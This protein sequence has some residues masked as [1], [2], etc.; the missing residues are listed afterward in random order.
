VQKGILQRVSRTF[1]VLGKEKN[2][3]PEIS[4]KIKSIYKKTKKEFPYLAVCIWN[5][6]WLNE[7][8]IHQP[9]RFYILLEVEKD[10][11]ESVFY[12][13]REKD[14]AVFLEPKKDVF[15]KYLPENKEAI[16]VKSLVSE[17]PVISAGGIETASIEKILVDIF[18]DGVIFSAYQGSE[19]LRIF[20]SAFTKYT[21]NQSKMFRYANRRGKKDELVRFTT[22]II[23]TQYQ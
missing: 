20:E 1:Y 8:M 5:T 14:S 13:L 22:S 18:C 4:S 11:A 7:F 6:K 12:Y 9:N 23:Q 21:V 17:A 16:I 19:M 3:I 10:V 2:Y 15:E